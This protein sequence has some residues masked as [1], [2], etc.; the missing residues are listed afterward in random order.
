M[1][2]CLSCSRRAC[3]LHSPHAIFN[4]AIACESLWHFLRRYCDR[5]NTNTTPFRPLR[6]HYDLNMIMTTMAP[7]RPLRNHDDH[8]DTTTLLWQKT[9]TTFFLKKCSKFSF[10]VANFGDFWGLSQT[11]ISQPS[12]LILHYS[13]LISVKLLKVLKR[14]KGELDS[15][16]SRGNVLTRIIIRRKKWYQEEH[17]EPKKLEFKIHYQ[18]HE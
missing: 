12:I 3:R 1:S 13:V 7:L 4:N 14:L 8:Y 16:N 6:H 2:V 18:H 17:K 15:E 5:Y 10:F 11:S 9:V